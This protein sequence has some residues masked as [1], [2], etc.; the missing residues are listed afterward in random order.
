MAGKLCQVC[1]KP[2][3][4]YPLCRDCFI[5]R[6]EGL[7]FKNEETGKWE[8]LQESEVIVE[9]NTLIQQIE[10]L[11]E[12]NRYLREQLEN[13]KE[14]NSVTKCILCD[15]ETDGHHFCKSC[16][17]KYHNKFIYLKVEGCKN[18]TIESADYEG[19]YICADGH[20]VKSQAERAIDDYLFNNGIPH[21][22][23]KSLPIDANTTFKPDFYLTQKNIY[24]EH[25]G[26]QNN[27]KYDETKEYKL[28]KYRT[29]QKPITL[30][31][32][33][34][35]DV[36]DINGVLDRRLSFYNENEINYEKE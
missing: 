36:K 23:E 18:Y 31:C 6:D 33:Y 35:E 30:I 8:L 11:E 27:P 24:I 21:A 12:E 20:V 32:M 1:G 3:G 4:I 14:V 13:K 19:I 22:Y 34:P 5:L 9:T 7:I 15:K 2:S 17:N 26:V 29:M 25:W 16:Y 28:N 10:E